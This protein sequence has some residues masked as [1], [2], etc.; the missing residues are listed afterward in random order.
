MRLQSRKFAVAFKSGYRSTT[1]AAG[2]SGRQLA[3]NL[4]KRRQLRGIVRRGIGSIFI[5]PPKPRGGDSV[6]VDFSNSRAGDR[7]D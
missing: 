7:P 1:P 5:C 3:L 4:F 6:S 2:Q